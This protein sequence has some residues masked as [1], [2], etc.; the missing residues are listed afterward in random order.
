MTREETVTLTQYIHAL[1]PQQA[2]DK[3]TPIAWHDVLGHLDFAE[4]RAAA[5]AVA[6]RQPFVAPAE[7]I[8]EIADR[9]SVDQPH[10]EACRQG[11]HRDC[12][13]TW[14]RCTCHPAA[15]DK[16]AGPPAPPAPAL[17]AGAR[18]GE[19]RQITM[20]DFPNGATP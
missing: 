17:T 2:V 5:V 1:C 13:F 9:R 11:R 6:G 18:G 20:P 3:F 10:T 19:P 14:C 12:V 16:L 7:I 8:R 4:C 15:I